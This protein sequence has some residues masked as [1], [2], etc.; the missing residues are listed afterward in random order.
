MRNGPCDILRVEP[1]VKIDRGVYARHDLIRA[2][3]ESAAPHGVRGVFGL[4]HADLTEKL[5]KLLLFIFVT[6]FGAA[7]AFWLVFGPVAD[8]P[9][10][11]GWMAKFTLNDP[12]LPAPTIKLQTVDGEPV[13]LAAYKDKIVLVNFW[14]TWCVPCVREM[15]SLDRLQA[16]FDKENFLILAVSVDREGAVKVVPFLKKHGIRNITT[17]LDQSMRL[18]SALRVSGMPTSFMLD[19]NGRVVGSL[20]GIAEWDSNEAKAL[21]RYYL[22]KS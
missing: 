5:M 22:E 8:Q 16:S 4:V 11:E 14:A 7:G 18:A 20:A 13:T 10:L 17:L 2:G 6:V 9:P 1:L 12:P 21:V 3:R 19:R 15:P